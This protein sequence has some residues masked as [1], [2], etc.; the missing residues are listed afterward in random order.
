MV[1]VSKDENTATTRRGGKR[2]G[3]GRKKSGKKLGG[4]HRRRPEVS[5]RHPIHIVLRLNR[6]ELRQGKTYRALR[7][8]LPRYLGNPDFRIVHLSIQYNHLHLLVEAKSRAVLTSNMRS[9]AINAARAINA[10]YAWYGNVI[11]HRYH[12]T[13]ITTPRQ[14]RNA[15]SYVL[16]NWRRHREDM[17]TSRARRAKLDPYATGLSFTGWRGAPKFALPA[18]YVPLPVSP[19]RSALLAS[20]W[21]QYGLI[22]MFETPG[23]L[24]SRYG[25]R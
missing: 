22:D 10:A 6:I 12:A 1:V 8:V 7:R 3:A 18:G 15:L 4:P 20:D 14:A 11:K 21:K 25:G 23:P 9:F 17:R 13:Q 5:S 24:A 2:A 16:N 19:P